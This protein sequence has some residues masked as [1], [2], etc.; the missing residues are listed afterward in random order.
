MHGSIT[1]NWIELSRR[2]QAHRDV[3]ILDLRSTQSY[4]K[5]GIRRFVEYLRDAFRIIRCCFDPRQD[6][7]D[8]GEFDR[9]AQAALRIAAVVL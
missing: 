9:S 6:D 4:F 2:S 1:I 7:F 8:G 3:T 5:L